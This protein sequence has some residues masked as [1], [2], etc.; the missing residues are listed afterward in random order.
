MKKIIRLT[1]SDLIRLVKRVIN[2]Q[3]NQYYDIEVKL[4]SGSGTNLETGKPDEGEP[5]VIGKPFNKFRRR[6]QGELF[7]K[8]IV[9]N[10]NSKLQV[11]RGGNKN[12][13]FIIS[14]NSPDEKKY[15]IFDLQGL[16]SGDKKSMPTKYA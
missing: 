16:I 5:L 10:A 2:E 1:E 13:D 4:I 11:S 14:N 8:I 15:D 7:P 9:L 3:D 12:L 6:T